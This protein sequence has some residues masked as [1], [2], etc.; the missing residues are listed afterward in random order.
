MLVRTA[1]DFDQVRG[2]LTEHV[3][4]AKAGQ[5][6]II[7][8]EA[9]VYAGSL[10]LDSTDNPIDITVR[11]QG[12]VW[13]DSGGVNVF[14]RN[15]VVEGLHFRG[16]HGSYFLQA[17]GTG[18]VDASRITFQGAS[19]RAQR[20]GGS[21]RGALA[22]IEAAG[23]G[24]PITLRDWTIQD[25]EVAGASL[26]YLWAQPNARPGPQRLERWTVAN[27]NAS[28]VVN[29]SAV[30]D[31]RFDDAWMQAPVGSTLVKVHSAAQPVPWR[32]GRV[33]VDSPA[34]FISGAEAVVSDARLSSRGASLDRWQGDGASVDA[35][36]LGASDLRA[37]WPGD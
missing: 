37:A 11:G 9:G 3:Y 21:S 33:V 13:F 35:A 5:A 24:T 8:L 15:V 34:A 26:V 12:E 31:L 36:L 27:N 23:N 18:S 1:A 4:G 28:V 7:T 6:L 22:N 2:L 10:E 25:S 16:A 30:E 17:S 19:V 29:C 14:G 32:G 20:R